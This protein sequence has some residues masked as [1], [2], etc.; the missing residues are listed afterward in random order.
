VSTFPPDIGDLGRRLA[1]LVGMPLLPESGIVN[2]YNNN[3]AHMGCHVDDAEHDL[4]KPVVGISLATTGLFLLGGATR[5]VAPTA[6]FIRSGDVI[7]M[8]GA[9]RLFYHGVPRIMVG[10]LP[11]HL[12]DRNLAAAHYLSNQAARRPLPSDPSDP[13]ES[14]KPAV[15]CDQQDTG[16][17]FAWELLSSKQRAELELFLEYL[18]TCRLNINMR[19]VRNLDALRRQAE[20]ELNHAVQASVFHSPSEP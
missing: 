19:Q 16:A 2:Y 4:T 7:V 8:G 17:A 5:Q 20:A 6:F 3:A 9:S 1:A 11:L 13:T 14:S 10:D 15:E 12:S 18:S